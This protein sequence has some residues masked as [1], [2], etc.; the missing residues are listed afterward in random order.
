MVFVFI[1]HAGL[2]EALEE[3]KQRQHQE[4]Q[5]KLVKG[6]TIELGQ[7]DQRSAPRARTHSADEATPLQGT[8]S[9]EATNQSGNEL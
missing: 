7:L 9:S 2:R 4:R 3:E 6:Q 5:S 8:N 1:S